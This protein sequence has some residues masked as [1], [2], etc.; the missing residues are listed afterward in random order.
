MR[1]TNRAAKTGTLVL[2][3]AGLGGAVL[4]S[5]PEPADHAVRPTV[6]RDLDRWTMPL[7]GFAQPG[8]SEAGYAES[9]LDQPCLRALGIDFPVP[10]ATVD[11]LSA[12]SV[13]DEGP[14]RGNPSPALAWS[15]PLTTD[16]AAERGYH[17]APQEGANRDGW[18]AW[19]EDADHRAAFDDVDQDAVTRCFEDSRRELGTDDEDGAVQTASAVAKRLTFVAADAARRDPAVTAAADRWRT[20]LDPSTAQ[21]LPDDPHDMPTA[22]IRQEFEIE[23]RPAASAGEIALAEEDVACQSSSG[24]RRALYDAEWTL[25]LHVTATDAAAL[26]ATDG[27]QLAAAER[28]RRTIERLAPEAPAGVD[29]SD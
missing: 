8:S 12:E 22:A 14:E 26:E 20:C 11:G 18:R 4:H 28:V 17:P 19:V 6:E 5:S 1:L 3:V 2:V 7:D 24:Y 15:R 25:L 13:A 27:D 9:L 23:A 16:A 10:W 21:A 29:G